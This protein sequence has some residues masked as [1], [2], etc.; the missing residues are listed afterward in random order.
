MSNPLEQVADAVIA[1]I[2]AAD[3]PL[4]VHAVANNGQFDELLEDLGT[5]HCDVVP[6]SNADVPLAAR[7]TKRYRCPIGIG[8]RKRFGQEDTDAETGLVIQSR[9]HELEDVLQAI[10]DLFTGKRLGDDELNA[11]WVQ[12]DYAA[13]YSRAHLRENRQ[14][15]GIIRMTFDAFREVPVNV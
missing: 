8:L 7:G 12:T 6:V 2:N 1:A 4:P 10:E 13:N 3:L 9:V 5:L 14:F 15:T 11:A